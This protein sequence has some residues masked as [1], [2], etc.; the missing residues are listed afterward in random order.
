MN[1]VPGLISVAGDYDVGKSSFALA[2][3]F[4]K[5]GEIAVFNSDIRDVQTLDTIG[6]HHVNLVTV[7]EQHKLELDFHNAVMKMIDGIEPG[8]YKVIIFDTWHSFARTFHA[9]VLKHKHKY[10][11]QLVGTG[12][13]IGGKIWAQV[14]RHEGFVI[15]AL[16]SKAPTLILTAHL[17]THYESG[18]KT[19]LRVPAFSPAVTKASAMKL[20]LR[21]QPNSP[22]PIAL[23][24]K[25]LSTRTYDKEKQCIRTVSVL[26]QKITPTSEDTSLWDTILRYIDN[27]IGLRE[28]TPEETLTEREITDMAGILSP[29]D[30]DTLLEM[31]KHAPVEE[32]EPV[33]F[34]DDIRAMLA[35]GVSALDI[36]KA[37]AVPVSKVKELAE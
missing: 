7:A 35:K 27:P 36:A 6:V 13:I 37:F 34:D 10:T 21:K 16:L 15:N 32:K 29:E 22:V 18:H 33:S 23:V 5:P 30:R 25:R 12:E 4:V 11:S 17:K 20:W 26:P 14:R 1:V 31:I 8:K 28:P 9:Y 19:Q 24:E 2:Y 3:P